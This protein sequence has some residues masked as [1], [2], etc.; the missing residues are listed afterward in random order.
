MT[1]RGFLLLYLFL[2]RIEGVE[3][4]EKISN[5]ETFS[6]ISK[7]FSYPNYVLIE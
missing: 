5:L 7:A 6:A 2:I 4:T 3:T 1:R